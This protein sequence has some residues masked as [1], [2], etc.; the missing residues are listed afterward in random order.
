[1][2]LNY[3]DLFCKPNPIARFKQLLMAAGSCPRMPCGSP[4]PSQNA[5]LERV[6]SLSFWRKGSA[7]AKKSVVP[8]E[9]KAAI[10]E[11]L[12]I[13]TCKW[14]DWALWLF[15]EPQFASIAKPS[16]V[17]QNSKKPISAQ[18]YAFLSIVDSIGP[19]WF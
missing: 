6:C 12:E 19:C 5:L 7:K 11:N 2:S 8:T 9:A 4:V 18:H 14:L 17:Y 16:L 3:G 10:K 15:L 1:M 13:S